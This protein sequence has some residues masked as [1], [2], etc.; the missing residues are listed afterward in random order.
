MFRDLFPEDK[1]KGFNLLLPNKQSGKQKDQ[2]HPIHPK[3]SKASSDC[4]LRHQRAPCGAE[5][6]LSLLGGGQGPCWSCQMPRV[7]GHFM[8][9]KPETGIENAEI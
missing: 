7:S 3:R 4:V 1:P 8:E 9:R 6:P 2:S 5:R